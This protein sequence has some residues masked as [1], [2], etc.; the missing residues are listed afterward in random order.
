MRTV[1]GFAVLPGVSTPNVT[2][3]EWV[4]SCQYTPDPDGSEVDVQLVDG[5]QMIAKVFRLGLAGVRFVSHNTPGQWDQMLLGVAKW[6]P[7]KQ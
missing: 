3:G 4:D 7:R 6:R 1:V 2:L 5:T